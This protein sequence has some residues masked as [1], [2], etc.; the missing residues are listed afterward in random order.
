MIV[1]Y[2]IIYTNHFDRPGIKAAIYKIINFSVFTI[3][4]PKYFFAQ[5]SCVKNSCGEI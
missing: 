2:Y 1:S 4:S 5:L 3:I